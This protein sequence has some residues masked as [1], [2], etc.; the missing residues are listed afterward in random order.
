MA[1]GKLIFVNRLSKAKVCAQEAYD[2]TVNGL[3]VAVFNDH[4]RLT[5][6]VAEIL[7]QE[8]FNIIAG[9]F[10][11]KAGEHSQSPL[12]CYSLRSDGSLNVASL[13]KMFGG[14]G[15]TKAAGYKKDT[16]MF[17]DPF[18]IFRNDLSHYFNSRN[19]K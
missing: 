15:H 11:S 14:N 18:S 3:R 9:F 13:A 19:E 10:Y 8:G 5:S 1:V 12:L 16:C 7:R 4:D 6:D 17:D 2:V